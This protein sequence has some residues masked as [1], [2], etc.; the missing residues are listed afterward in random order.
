MTADG[1]F[2][3]QGDDVGQAISVS[4]GLALSVELDEFEALSGF[5][6]AALGRASRTLTD[7]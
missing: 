3:A 7:P 6:L 4:S 1:S 5:K 2:E